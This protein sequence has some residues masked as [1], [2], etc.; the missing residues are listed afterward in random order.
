MTQNSE[1]GVQAFRDILRGAEMHFVEPGREA[2]GRGHHICISGWH[3]ARSFKEYKEDLVDLLALET[4]LCKE[5]SRNRGNC[6]VNPHKREVVV[7]KVGRLICFFFIWESVLL[8]HE[9]TNHLTYYSSSQRMVTSRGSNCTALNWT[10][11]ILYQ[12]DIEGSLAWNL[13]NAKDT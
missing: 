6:N 7:W 1:L 5:K 3:Q 11:L 9:E 8:R 12:R 10:V 13:K 2:I 4:Y